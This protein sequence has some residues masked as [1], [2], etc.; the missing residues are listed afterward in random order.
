MEYRRFI[1]S[2]PGRMLLYGIKKKKKDGMDSE[3]I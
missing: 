2:V 1:E 3:H